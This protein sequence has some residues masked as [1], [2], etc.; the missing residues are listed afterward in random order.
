MPYIVLMMKKAI[1]L[2][3]ITIGFLSAAL[4]QPAGS[5]VAVNGALS[6]KGGKI[7]NKNGV[8]PQLRGISLSW[9]L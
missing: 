1:L 3:L 5:P 6:V 9:S 4:A 2:L 7:V 8:P